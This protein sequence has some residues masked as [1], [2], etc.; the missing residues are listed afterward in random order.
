[1]WKVNVIRF[2]YHSKQKKY[3]LEIKNDL[4]I[5]NDITKRDQEMITCDIRKENGGGG[6]KLPKVDITIH[7]QPLRINLGACASFRS[8][9]KGF[10]TF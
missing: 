3:I 1:M 4:Y 6:P 9:F 2:V 7:A 10:Y 5:D 8:L